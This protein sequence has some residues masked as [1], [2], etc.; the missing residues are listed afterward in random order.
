MTNWGL[1]VRPGAEV[2]EESDGRPAVLVHSAN[3]S[4]YELTY[5]EF[6]RFSK[7]AFRECRKASSED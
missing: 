7:A 5:G 3:G 4:D 2:I 6:V 1:G